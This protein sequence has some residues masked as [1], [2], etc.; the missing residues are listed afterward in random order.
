MVSLNF[1]TLFNS[2]YLSR[3]L[4]LYHSL[5]CCCP[6]FHLYVYAFDDTTYSYLNSQNFKHLTVISL[7]EFEDEQLLR[8]K[9]TRTAGEYCWTCSS[10]TILYSIEKFR[11]S[12]CTYIDA[13][14]YFYSNPSVLIEEMGNKSVLITEHRYTAAYDQSAVSGKYCVQFMC[15]KNTDEGMKVLRW[16]RNACIDWCYGRVEDGKFGD[17]KYLDSWTQQFEGVH[18]LQHLGGGLAPWNMQ[19]YN[20]SKKEKKIYGTEISTGKNFE[21]VFFHFHGL[22]LFSDNIVSLTGQTYKMNPSALDVFFKPYVNELISTSENIHSQTKHTFDANGANT[23]SPEKP[24]NFL[25]LLRFYIYDIRQSLQNINGK[26]TG[27]RKKHHHYFKIKEI[28]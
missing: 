26:K 15:F 21:V 9:P 18:E 6:R 20:F 25:S 5:V 12:N 8:I 4:A 1:C 7:K 16:W 27:L 23:A 24:L 13:D 10:S 2:A 11:L 22:K 19:Q 3:G 14:M 17:Q 28:I